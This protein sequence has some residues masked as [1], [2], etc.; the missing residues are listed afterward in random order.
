MLYRSFS[1]IL[2]CST[3]IA[4]GDKM[5]P[6]RAVPAPD[7]SAVNTGSVV[8]SEMP[9]EQE[10]SKP[11]GAT[12][13]ESPQALDL[14]LPAGVHGD[15]PDMS[16]SEKGRYGVEAW[17]DQ[18]ETDEEPRFKMKTKL[19]MKEGTEFDKNSDISS[20]G[21]SVDGA[22]MGFEYKTR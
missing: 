15:V 12:P 16:G 18:S 17:F 20:Y 7:V 2:I 6:S 11:K 19:R 21:Q 9:A 14:S 8:E 4:C 22:E 10:G 1:V 3:L 13:P 5:E